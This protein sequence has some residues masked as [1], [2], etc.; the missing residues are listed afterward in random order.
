MVEHR[1][2]RDN[3]REEGEPH[4]GLEHDEQA[5]QRRVRQDVAE[6][7]GEEGRAAAIQGSPKTCAA[8]GRDERG[9]QAPQEQGEA[10]DQPGGPH[11][12][13]QEERERA[14]EA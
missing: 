7:E 11:P 8:P 5:P 4:P 3:E 12:D 14:M 13:E 6:A 2:I 1:Y 9:A 10:A